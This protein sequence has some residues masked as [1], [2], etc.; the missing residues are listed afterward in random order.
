MPLRKPRSCLNWSQG[1]GLISGVE[2][3]PPPVLLRDDLNHPSV[4]STSRSCFVPG[5]TFAV[6]AL[7]RLGEPNWGERVIVYLGSL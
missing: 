3:A 5:A 4:S 7:R 1:A 6:G 2:V